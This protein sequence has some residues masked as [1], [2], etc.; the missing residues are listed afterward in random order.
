M[1]TPQVLTVLLALLCMAFSFAQD[2]PQND[3]A[4]RQA[5]QSAVGI[6]RAGKLDEA[7]SAFESLQEKAP[8]NPDVLAWLGFLYLRREVP[9]KAVPVLEKAAAIR[10]KD[11]EVL[12]NLGNAYVATGENGKALEMYRKVAELSPKMFEPWYNIG[13]ILLAE[14]DYPK[15]FDAF[16]K[17]AGLKSDDAFVQNNLGATYEALK[18]TEQAAAAYLRAATLRPDNRIFARNAAFAYL[19]LRQDTKA[20]P[21]LEKAAADPKDASVVLALAECYSRLNRRADALRLLES[22]QTDLGANATFWFNLGVLRNEAGEAEG[23]EIAYRNALQIDE[24]DPDTLNNLG[25]LL[26]KQRKYDEAADLFGRL[27][28]IAT[29]N[30]SA[31]LNQASALA[32]AGKLTRATEIWKEVVKAEPSKLDA[33]LD[34]AAALWKLG[35]KEGAKYHYTQVLMQDKANARAMNGLGLW[36]L[37]EAKNT[38]AET[39]FR[40]AIAAKKDYLPA[41]VNL[42]VTLEKLNRRADAIK[43]LEQALKIDP[44]NEDAKKNLA[45]MKG[46]G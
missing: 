22:M 30:T 4:I 28:G 36:N 21:F 18:Q 27:A 13:N 7:I 20:L 9:A 5:V 25:L 6:Y 31:K 3:N 40:Q 32:M 37:D 1:K 16:K 34:L 24:N 43:V 12:N 33:R 8:E 39:Y 41:Y 11:L 38:E 26:F 42:A 19:R 45:R 2:P 35:D 44:K 29:A 15:A 23:A 46:A 17:A 10:P 14:K